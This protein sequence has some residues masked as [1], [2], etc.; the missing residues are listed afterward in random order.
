M[1]VQAAA[2]DGPWGCL[3]P[4]SRSVHLHIHVNLPLTREILLALARIC[5]TDLCVRPP[6]PKTRG[7]QISLSDLL[8]AYRLDLR[9]RATE[10]HAREVSRLVRDL[11]DHA[12]EADPRAI[13]RDQVARFLEFC[14]STGRPHRLADGTITKRRV[15]AGAKSRR[16]YLSGLR[17]FYAWCIQTERGITKNPCESVPSPRVLRKQQ[18]A[19]TIVEIAALVEAAPFARSVLYQTLAISGVRVG[20]LLALPVSA[21]MLEDDQPRIE[22]EAVERSKIRNAYSAALDDATA[23]RLVQL[24][25]SLDEDLTP[26]VRMFQAL[27]RNALRKQLR[28]DCKRAGVALKDSKGRS[29]GLHCFRRG[30]VTRLLDLG[31]DAKVAQLQAGHADVSTTLNNYTDRDISDQ[32]AAVARLADALGLSSIT[33]HTGPSPKRGESGA[34]IS[35]SVDDGRTSRDIHGVRPQISIQRSFGAGRSAR[36]VASQPERGGRPAPTDRD[37][38]A[39]SRGP[40]SRKW[41]ILDSNQ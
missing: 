6:P 17:K 2:R 16:T 32:T 5:G 28:S 35:K 39:R 14:G 33:G 29:V 30:M 10:Q 40:A 1:C 11:C 24:R 18:R 7:I 34:K 38:P 21:F 36:F 3:L 8:D 13:S 4:R 15:R 27:R 22:L 9:G 26:S 23:A 37:T 31:A 25:D 12:G 41:A 20:A 19:F